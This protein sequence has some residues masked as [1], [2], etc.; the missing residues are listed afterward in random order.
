MAAIG[1]TIYVS[2]A[3][4]ASGSPSTAITGLTSRQVLFGSPTGGVAQMAGFQADSTQGFV[5]IGTSAPAGQLDVM[6]AGSGGAINPPIRLRKG[7]LGLGYTT[8]NGRTV[9][10]V[11]S[12]AG[13]GTYISLLASSGSNQAGFF[14]GTTATES[15][16]QIRYNYANDALEFNTLSAQRANLSASGLGVGINPAQAQL[17]AQTTVNGNAFLVTCTTAGTVP[18]LCVES[19]G[20]SVKFGAFTT[21]TAAQ[22]SSYT[23]PSTAVFT[24]A[25][26]S[27]AT[28]IST[29][30]TNLTPWGFASSAAMASWQNAIIELQQVVSNIVRDNSAGL[31]GYGWFK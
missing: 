21:V 6:S 8:F 12:S 7:A 15:I 16:G 25:S 28:T 14:F 22:A 9:V 2:N 18:A 5:G 19:S 24:T 1:E 10:V 30:S 20:T 26:R 27:L 17:H 11:E 23:V 29:N 31:G 4:A 3:A 13:G